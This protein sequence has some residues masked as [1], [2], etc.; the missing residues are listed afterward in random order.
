MARGEG[1]WLTAAAWATAVLKNGL[2][3]YDEALAAAEQ[4]AECPHELG[5]ATWSTAELIEAAARAGAPERA[6]GAMA[7]LSEITTASGTDWA[8]GIRA[9]CRALL[10]DG[11]SA[12]RLYLEAITRLGHTRIRAELAR[13]YLLYGEWLRQNRR[14]DAREPL[15]LAYQMLAE[16]GF[17]GF[18][19][20]A[21]REL[22]ATGE[23]VRKRTIETASELTAQEAQIA[24]LAG[25]GH[26]NTEIGG[27]LFISGRTVEW[28]LHKVFAK[29][30]IS[31]R[32]ELREALPELG[33]PADC[34]KASAQRQA[35]LLECFLD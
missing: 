5:L 31:C 18:A 24:R 20:R 26:T 32:Q 14:I 9:R 33:Q 25:D 13:A 30:G 6:A 21:R 29:L 19:E 34:C 17:D 22:L 16:M 11:E 2:G 3:R 15:R 10:S 1:Q 4:G 8:L 27:R 12:E 28:H 23:T 7:R 35:L